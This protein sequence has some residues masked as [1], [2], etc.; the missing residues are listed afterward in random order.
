MTRRVCEV[1]LTE[2]ARDDLREIFELTSDRQSFAAAAE[3]IAKLLDKADELMSF[4]ERGAVPKELEAL[5]IARFRQL[6]L[7]PYRI[8][9]SV[10]A[11]IVTIVFVADGR[12]DMRTLLA[13][14]LLRP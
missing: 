8:I 5:G 11:D 1:R 9:Y 4:P 13:R 10:D 12:R 6:L 7:A 14:R 3:L 2:A